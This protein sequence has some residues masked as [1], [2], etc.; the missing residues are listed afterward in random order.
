LEQFRAQRPFQQPDLLAER[1]LRHEQPLGG[2]G[3]VQLLS[4]RHEVA[5]VSTVDIQNPW[6]SP[7]VLEPRSPAVTQFN[8][9]EISARYL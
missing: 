1:G 5:E 6:L 7:K 3:E 4:H 2:P 8:Q 9:Q